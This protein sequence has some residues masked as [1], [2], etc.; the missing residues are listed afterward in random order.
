MEFN[1]HRQNTLS[2]T[3]E[4]SN[5]SRNV[6]KLFDPLLPIC[7]TISLKIVNVIQLDLPPSFLDI[8]TK[9]P[10]F[11]SDGIRVLVRGIIATISAYFTTLV[12]AVATRFS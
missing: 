3:I 7:V 12:S 4:R 11:F 6:S 2:I 9:Y 1:L 8:V 10:G 5:N